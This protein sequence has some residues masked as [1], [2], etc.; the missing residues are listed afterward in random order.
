MWVPSIN[1]LEIFYQS[2]QKAYPKLRNERLMKRDSLESIL[3]VVKHGKPMLKPTLIQRVATLLFDLLMEHCYSDVNKRIGFLSSVVF[4]RKNGFTFSISDQELIQF[5]L[6]IGSG[7]YLFKDVE[8]IIEQNIV[9]QDIDFTVLELIDRY[10]DVL[11]ALG[12]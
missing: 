8:K 7:K 5:V 1:D 12:E 3:D 10:N 9:K 4:L 11:V 2:L 6:D